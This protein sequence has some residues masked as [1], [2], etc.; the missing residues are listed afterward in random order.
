MFN[1]QL[2]VGLTATIVLAGCGPTNNVRTQEQNQARAV[3]TKAAVYTQSRDD[4]LARD[5][6]TLPQNYDPS[7]YKK[8]RVATSFY[9]QDTSDNSKFGAEKVATLSSLFE[10]EISKLKRFTVLSRSQIGQQAIRDEKRFQDTGLVA[11]S[12]LMR[13][14]QAKGADYVLT[15]GIAI[16]SET[17]ERVKNQELILSVLVDYKLINVETQEV[18]EADTAPGRAKRTFYQTPGGTWVG[19]FNISNPKEADQALAEASYEALKVIANKIGNKLPVGG[20]VVGI[21]GDNFQLDAGYE[22]GLMGKQ[23]MAV[24]AWDGIDMPLAYA[25]VSPGK[26]KSNG[27]IVKWNNDPAAQD[28]IARW[29]SEGMGFIRDTEVYAVSVAMPTPPEWDN[30]YSN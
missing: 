1:K 25:E 23:Q 3:Q 13:L 12:D 28:L 11:T 18:I 19:G 9:P 14:G 16:K 29:R 6:V 5:E 22:Q 10:T 7:N 17:F 27:K 2:L 24:Y 26:N 30:N 4:I 21:K 20:Q 8:L 15:G